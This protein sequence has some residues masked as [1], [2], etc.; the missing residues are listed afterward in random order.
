MKKQE[1]EKSINWHEYGIGYINIQVPIFDREIQFELFSENNEHPNVSD[2]IYSTIEDVLNLPSDSV[3]KIKTLL[4]EECNFSFTVSD[5]GCEPIDEET[6]KQAHFREFELNNEQDAFDKCVIKGVQIHY[7]SDKLEARYAEIKIDTATDNLISLIV[8][9]GKIIDYDDDGTFL[10][11]FEKD[12]EH[13]HNKRM[14]VMDDYKA[15][16][17]QRT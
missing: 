11:W 13:A 8:K 12:E 3:E 15:Y 6:V 1:L 14:K 5:Y 10:G 9:N 2:K 16:D 4:W 17:E 7:E